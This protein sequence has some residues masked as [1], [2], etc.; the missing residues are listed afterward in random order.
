[1]SKQ[2]KAKKEKKESSQPT[3]LDGDVVIQI[4]KSD[5]LLYKGTVKGEVDLYEK[6]S[7]LDLAKIITRALRRE[8]RNRRVH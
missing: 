6:S 1:M 7:S 5:R 3:I 4:A 2:G 8:L